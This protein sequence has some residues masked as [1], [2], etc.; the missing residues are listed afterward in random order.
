MTQSTSTSSRYREIQTQNP[1]V[2]RLLLLLLLMLLLPAC[3][4]ARPLQPAVPCVGQRHTTSLSHCTLHT[5]EFDE[6]VWACQ[7]F[8]C[9]RWRR[10]QS[11]IA[12]GLR[13]PLFDLQ[14]TLRG[15]LYPA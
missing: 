4:P 15:Y 10:A 5:D 11:S 14:S 8:E 1:K 6:L 12:S 7:I 13:R 3:R 9:S 2:C